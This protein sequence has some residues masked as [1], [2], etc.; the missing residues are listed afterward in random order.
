MGA[1]FG[2]R[3]W[4]IRSGRRAARQATWDEGAA[5]LVSVG[6]PPSRA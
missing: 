4:N 3:R 6:H 2:L 5:R 1:K